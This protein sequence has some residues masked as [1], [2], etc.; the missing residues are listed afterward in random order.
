MKCFACLQF[1]P[2]TRVVQQ[3]GVALAKGVVH[4]GHD[5]A[6]AAV[7]T[8]AVP[9]AHRLEAVAQYARVALQPDFTLRVGNALGLQ[10]CLQPGQ[11]A[12]LL[13]ALPAAMVGIPKRKPSGPVECQHACGIGLLA[14]RAHGQQ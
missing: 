9:K 10:Q 1:L 8:V 5:G 11:C 14:Q 3:V 2:I 13:R 6:Q 7:R 12:A 4:F